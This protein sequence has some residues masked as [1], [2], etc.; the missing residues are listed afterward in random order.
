MWWAVRDLIFVLDGDHVEATRL[1]DELVDC[2]VSNGVCACS[3]RY[4]A[5][6][7][8]HAGEFG[9]ALTVDHGEPIAVL[10]GADC[11]LVVGVPEHGLVPFDG[12][13]P[14]PLPDASTRARWAAPFAT[15]VGLVWIDMDLLFR[16]G[17]DGR[18]RALGR[19][20]G[21][22][23]MVVG[24]GGAVLVAREEDTLCA[25]PGGELR[26]VGDPLDVAFA[27]FAP[28]GKRALVAD[29]DGVVELDLRAGRVLRRWDGP[30]T[31]V[32][33]TPGATWLDGRDGV[34]RDEHGRTLLH[35]FAGT[36]A[37]TGGD[38]L[39]GPGGAV[40]SLATGERLR[41]GL[42]PGVAA[43][44]GVRVVVADETDVYVLDGGRFA[45]DL[46]TDE[47][48]VVELAA[49]FGDRIA[50]QT[51]SGAR[52]DFGLTGE[53]LGREAEGDW[54]PE[55][56]DHPDVRLSEPGDPS[57][58]AIGDQTWPLAADGVCEVAGQ[59]WAWSIEGALY[60]LS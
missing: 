23:A 46:T 50:V 47:Q 12:G 36:G 35:G 43:T 45:H 26:T 58:L 4:G 53:E 31:P 8:D 51:S 59:H 44:D 7:V 21:T 37:A 11:V 3:T 48:E 54:L 5:V 9:T 13:A 15:G 16:M 49:V 18:P 39:A 33:Y 14:L 40:W 24:P 27:R 6:R 32:G 22:Q 2:A 10:P 34:V 25:P 56:P 57:E 29:E 38:W 1:P 20:G 42:P 30:L 17:D 19:A 60:A 41:D 55:P 52:A 28:D